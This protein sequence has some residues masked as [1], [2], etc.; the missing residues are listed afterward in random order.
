MCIRDSATTELIPLRTAQAHGVLE[1]I[2]PLRPGASPSAISVEAE[3]PRGQS[4]M[5]ELRGAAQPWS[6]PREVIPGTPIAV[7]VGDS[8]ALDLR[9]TFSET[10]PR[11]D[12]LAS[13]SARLEAV[14]LI[15]T[16]GTGPEPRALTVGCV[17][18]PG[19]VGPL[20]FIV[21]L[22]MWWRRTCYPPIHDPISDQA[23]IEGNDR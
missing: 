18:A 3:V 2:L 10:G 9:F 7:D 5:I 16:G 23:R 17:A 20:I 22:G 15:S 14:T 21:L 12:A 13:N 4:L 1:W 11:F 6:T 19:P 8:G